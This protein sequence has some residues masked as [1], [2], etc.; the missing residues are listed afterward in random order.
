MIFVFYN[1]FRLGD[2]LA[3]ME[4]LRNVVIN[5]PEHK[6]YYF[7]KLY[8]EKHCIYSN[9]KSLEYSNK[10]KKK[11]LNYCVELHTKKKYLPY[12]VKDDCVLIDTWSNYIVRPYLSKN[13]DIYE[14]HHAFKDIIFDKLNL[15]FPLNNESKTN[16]QLIPKMQFYNIDRFDKLFEQ[17]KDKKKVFYFNN[18][19]L[20]GQMLNYNHV[21]IIDYISKKYPEM[22]FIICE[23]E[24][25]KFNNNVYNCQDLGFNSTWRKKED[26][27]GHSLYQMALISSKCDIAFFK[28]TG[29]NFFIGNDYEL[30]KIKN[31]QDNIKVFIGPDKRNKGYKDFCPWAIYFNNM[32]QQYCNKNFFKYNITVDWNEK[33]KQISEKIG[34]IINKAL[35]Q[36]NT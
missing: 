26:E 11:Y 17:Y 31:N 30:D 10:Y 19:G 25:H 24:N 35:L 27:S 33:E 8:N 14:Y 23:K 28:Q 22:I 4:I 3:V 1:L 15:N 34:N 18:N 6:F 21:P 2:H 29:R 9:I 20:S 5:N 32:S 12:L 13:W 16:K 36:L 7:N